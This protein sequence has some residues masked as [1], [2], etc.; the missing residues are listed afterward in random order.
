MSVR[1]IIAHIDHTFLNPLA[2]EKEMLDF[3]ENAQDSGVAS[4][5]VPPS[6]VPLLYKQFGDRVPLCTVVGF[7][8][9][10]ESTE[11]KVLSAKWAYEH[12]ARE[13][14]VVAPIGCIHGGNRDYLYNEIRL[15][16]AERPKNCIMKVILETGALSDRELVLTIKTLN[17]LD[18]DYYKTSTG[19]GFPGASEHAAKLIMEYKRPET[20]LKVS[21]GIATIVEAERYLNIGAD[22]LGSSRLLSACLNSVRE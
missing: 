10:Y 16:L 5:C 11:I 13:V 19:F 6:F 18:I 3:A 20:K 12:G 22:R 9:G 1:N 17:Q 8:N 7:P 21:G 4:L 14:D 2:T 15:I